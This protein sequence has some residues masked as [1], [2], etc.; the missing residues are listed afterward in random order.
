MRFIETDFQGLI[1]VEP[2]VFGDPRGYFLETYHAKKYAEAG[3]PGPFVQDNFSHSVRGTLRGLHYQKRRPQGKLVYVVEGAV[4][5]AVVDLRAGSPTFGRWFGVELSTE[6]KRQLYVPP[7]FA[8]GFC[9]VSE[10]ASFA[11]KCTDFY[12]PQ[13]EGGV[14]W[15][16]AAIGIRWPVTQ[17][18]L[19]VKDQG[20]KCLADIPES[21][22]PRA[23]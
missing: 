13:D 20:F 6:N 11:Y 17:P 7:G 23:R 22:L 3:I 15:N 16:D 19:S 14:L 18:L 10:R 8:H 1:L 5:D 9:V 4:F 12:A 2:D 21:D